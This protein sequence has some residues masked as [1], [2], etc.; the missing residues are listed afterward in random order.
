MVAAPEVGWM[1]LSICIVAMIH[2]I[3]CSHTPPF[4]PLHSPH[5]SHSSTLFS[6]FVTGEPNDLE[7]LPP[8]GLFGYH[9]YR[10]R[11]L[12]FIFLTFFLLFSFLLLF[13]LFYFL[14]FFFSCVLLFLLSSFLALSFFLSIFVVFFIS[15]SC[16]YFGGDDIFC[17]CR[18][19]YA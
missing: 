13:L 12:S 14:A 18:I 8:P 1:A 6:V 7:P 15:L 3:F 4:P 5:S 16:N 2:R 17:A 10:D 9:H 11:L 19:E